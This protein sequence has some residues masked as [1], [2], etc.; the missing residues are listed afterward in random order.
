MFITG[1]NNIIYPSPQIF[2]VKEEENLELAEGLA[3]RLSKYRKVSLEEISA[4]RLMDRIDVKFVVPVQMLPQL[5]EKAQPYY[6]VQ[7]IAMKR[8]SAYET[9]YLD[10]P[11]CYFYH[12][13]LNGKLNRCKVRFRKYKDTKQSFLEVKQ[14]SNKGRTSKVRVEHLSPGFVICNDD[15]NFL[16]NI[17]Q[18]QYSSNLNPVLLNNFFRVTLV[19]N[20]FTERLTIDFGLNFRNP[21]NRSE[22]N[23]PNLGIIEIK[24]DRFSISPMRE[25][26]ANYRIKKTGISKYCLG[27]TLVNHNLKSNRYKRKIHQL[28]KQLN[29]ELFVKDSK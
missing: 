27:M 2:K 18:L 5:L 14:K 20:S 25:L 24:Q 10:T 19:N 17:N 13:H 15:V 9:M 26:L 3:S 8:I 1:I 6:N 28:N 16:H 21:D 7:E 23:L 22:I 29:Y 11:D 12:S 4:V